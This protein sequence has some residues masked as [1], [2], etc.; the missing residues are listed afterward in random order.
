MKAHMNSHVAH[1]RHTM[2]QQSADNVQTR[3]EEMVKHVKD[4]MD[5]KTDEVF[6][7]M[8]RDYRSIIGGG[9]IPQEGEMLP[10]DQRLVRREVMKVIEGVEK[11]FMKVAGMSADDEDENKENDDFARHRDAEKEEE[12]AS[13][14]EEEEARND[15][16]KREMTPPDQLVD[17]EGPEGSPTSKV[18]R[19]KSADDPMSD[20]HESDD[21]SEPKML[22]AEAE[23]G[24]KGL[25]RNETDSDPD[26]SDK[27]EDSD[28]D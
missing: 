6:T 27:P 14:V 3:L 19:A 23:Q 9:D 17:G 12:Q 8:R 5:D 22:R 26:A 10:K 13:S 1:E 21:S 16:F 18:E 20:S 28:S 15:S 4:L 24:F 25:A 11:S 7:Q 2:F